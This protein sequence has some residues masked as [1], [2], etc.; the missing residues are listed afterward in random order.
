MPNMLLHINK[1]T[2]IVKTT[3]AAAIAARTATATRAMQ[4]FGRITELRLLHVG[5]Y[6]SCCRTK[7]HQ[8]TEGK[9]C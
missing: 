8:S 7:K 2:R 4:N 9:N 1:Q 6:P 5:Y 3:I